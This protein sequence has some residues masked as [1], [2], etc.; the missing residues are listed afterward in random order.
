MREAL[1]YKDGKSDKFWRVETEGVEM[2]LNWGR[3]GTAGRYEIKVFDSEEKCEREAA[4]L[5]AA[6]ARKG[7][8]VMQDFNAARHLYFDTDEYGLHSLT[9]N[10]IFREF[11]SDD[12][13]YDCG[14]EEAPFGSDEGN[15]ALRALEETLRRKPEARLADFPRRLIEN[16]WGLKYI[17]PIP[18]QSDEELKAQAEESYRGLPGSGEILQTDQVVIA[19]ALGQIKI[20]GKSEGGLCERALMSLTRME[21]MYR[22]LWNWNEKE[23]PYA[24]SIMRRDIENFM[25]KRVPS[26][27]N[28]K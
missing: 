14:D 6:K 16:E 4:K 12:L 26:E 1:H 27:R 7:Y 22:L 9:S 8:A 25:T 18:E 20:M 23:P 11:F 19:A 21:R 3:A 2:A 15:D 24:I 5:A 10:P 28:I 17:P 13:Y